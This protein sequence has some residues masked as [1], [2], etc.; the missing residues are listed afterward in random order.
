MVN[1]KSHPKFSN[2]YIV[3]DET[4]ER[5][6]T[7]NLTPGIRVYGEQLYRFKDEEYRAWDPFRSKLAAS[8][9][10]GII[11]IPIKEGTRILYLG[12]A[13][14]TTASHV[15]DIIGE[16]GKIFCIEFSPRVMKELIE[17]S[18]LRKNMIPILADARIPS[19]YRTFVEIVDVIYCDVAQPDQANILIDN[20]EYYLRKKGK[21]MIAI[22]ARSID[23]TKEP[24]EIFKKEIK[25]MEDGGI[26]VLDVKRLDPFDKDHAMVL[27][28]FT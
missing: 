22:K 21:V 18:K 12:A 26:R 3:E 5:L 19:S 15:S 4:I 13:S 7:K 2:I 6:A 23:V 28:E 1:V 8:I 27:G 20:A 10:K 25:I 14:G 24:T 16:K 9:E 17:V 11:E